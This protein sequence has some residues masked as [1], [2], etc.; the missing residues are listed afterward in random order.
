MTDTSAKTPVAIDRVRILIVEDQAYMRQIVRQT[1]ERM[2]VRHIYEAEEGG[3]GLKMTVRLRPDL[4]LCDI[5]MEPVNGL[6]YLENL[7]DFQNPEIARIPVVFLTVDAA[8]ETVMRSKAHA[9]SGYIVKP[10]SAARLR[11]TLNRILG[12]V[13]P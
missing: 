11:D 5:H 7:R 12:P 13:I 4:V 10:A 1:L 2:G 6:A 3:D 9:V 8:E